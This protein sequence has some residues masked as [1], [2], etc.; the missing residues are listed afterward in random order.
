MENFDE[1]QSLWNQQ[2]GSRTSITASAL[3]R[4]AESNIKKLKTGQAW[5]IAV[6]ATLSTILTGYFVW[7][8]AYRFNILAVGLGVM[9]GVILLR[10][11]LEWISVNKLKKIKPDSSMIEFGSRMADFYAWR[12]RIHFIFIPIIYICYIAGFAALLPSFKQNLSYGMYLYVI[13]SGFVSLLVLAVFI[14]KQIK[15]ET[16]ILILLKSI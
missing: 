16:K 3:I 11:L 12:R 1:L 14:G 13:I 7:I 8:G 5:T 9:I 6:L 2:A 10:I 15:K 4:K